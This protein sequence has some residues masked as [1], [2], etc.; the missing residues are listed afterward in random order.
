MF[1]EEDDTVIWDS[2]LIAEYL[3]ETYP[4]PNF[5]P[6]HPQTKL[7]C[8]KWEELAD[9]LGDNVIN[10]WI[11]KKYV[12]KVLEILLILAKSQLI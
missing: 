8:R 6:T 11:L 5:Y 3:D 9:N 2:T 12:L 10:L 4:E 7:E 1:V